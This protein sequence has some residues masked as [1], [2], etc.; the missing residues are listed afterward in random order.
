[1]VWHNHAGNPLM[2]SGPPSTTDPKDD[3]MLVEEGSGAARRM[4]CYP[5][6]AWLPIVTMLAHMRNESG[7]L[8]DYRPGT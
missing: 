3:M 2:V 5:R 8:A 4:L 7:K 1:M 6:Q